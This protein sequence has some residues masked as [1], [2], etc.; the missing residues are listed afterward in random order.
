MSRAATRPGSHGANAR[1]PQGGIALSGPVL[2]LVQPFQVEGQEG[3]AVRG[4]F[5]RLGPVLDD[6]LDRHAYPEPVGRLLAEM[7]TLASAMAAALKYDGIFTLQTKSDG[8]ISLMVADV[9]ANGEVRGYA[10]YDSARLVA[11]ESAVGPTVPRLLGKG[12]FAFTVDQGP[13]TERYQGVVDLRGDHFS[14]CVH[15]YFR[16]SE[17][18]DVWIK[19]A[20]GRDEAE[21][22]GSAAAPLRAAAMMLQ[23]IPGDDGRGETQQASEAEWAHA[24]A[25]ASTLRDAEML[26]PALTPP[27]LLHRL[28]HEHGV[29]VYEPRPVRR[30]CRCSRQRVAGVLQMLPDAELREMIVDGSAEVVCEFCAASFQFSA[31]ELEQLRRESAA[32]MP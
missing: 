17:Q 22:L 18:I 15:H 23:R 19:L 4:R 27:K 24:V 1:F 9:T 28:F 29:R 14:D 26:D 12:H 32:S 2:D 6:I 5:V 16:Q 13:H 25:L 11:A 3:G 30:G 21:R 8:A 7:L 20:A 10:Q 31:T